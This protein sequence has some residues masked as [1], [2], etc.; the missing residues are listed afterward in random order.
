MDDFI[1]DNLMSSP[2]TMLSSRHQEEL[3]KDLNQ[4]MDFI[5]F[6]AIFSLFVILYYIFKWNLRNISNSKLQLKRKA[7]ED[8]AEEEESEE[9]TNEKEPEEDST[10]IKN[11]T[12]NKLS[13][14]NVV[15]SKRISTE[16]KA[17]KEKEMREQ[18]EEILKTM[19]KK[20]QEI[21]RKEN[22]C[23]W[24]E[25]PIRSESKNPL[26]FLQDDD[27]SAVE[28]NKT[29]Q[30]NSNTDDFDP[31]ESMRNTRRSTANT[32]LTRR[33]TG[34]SG[35]PTSTMKTRSSRNR[36]STDQSGQNSRGNSSEPAA[37]YI[38]HLS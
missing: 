16:E 24:D 34:A 6:L 20:K 21:E 13:D 37:R 29:N 1:D 26:S 32:R 3:L 10:T 4:E 7:T 5:T 36:E 27:E 8:E 33:F 23:N 9:E 25:Q 18:E 19:T 2:S 31:N 28:R 11:M 15:E 38:I 17:R 14:V 30:E 12:P 22:I 35:I